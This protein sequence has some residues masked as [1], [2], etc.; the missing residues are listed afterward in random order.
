MVR[1]LLCALLGLLAAFTVA[2]WQYAGQQRQLERVMGQKNAFEGKALFLEK[3]IRER[4]E[5][6]V[7]ANKRMRELE[8]KASEERGKGGFDWGADISGSAVIKQLQ[9][10]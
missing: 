6:E 1:F 3:E 5:R 10:D 9:A 2:V 7:Y 4:N 8:E